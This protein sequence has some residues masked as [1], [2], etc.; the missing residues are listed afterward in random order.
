MNLGHIAIKKQAMIKFKNNSQAPNPHYIDLVSMQTDFTVFNFMPRLF[1]IT[2]NNSSC[3]FNT[4]ILIGTSTVI[5]NF[6]QKNPSNLHYHLNTN[7]DKNV[8]SKFEQIYKGESVQFD[9]S[10]IRISQLIAEELNLFG[11]NDLDSYSGVHRNFTNQ[12]K[13]NFLSTSNVGS[14][15]QFR[16]KEQKV[17]IDQSSIR[18]Y[19]Q[20]NAYYSFNIKT[21]KH[22]YRCSFYGALFS[23]VIREFISNEPNSKIFNFDY[24]DN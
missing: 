12:K 10:E 4:D 2:T 17:E 21:N 20:K 18:S 19:L 9:K 15:I 1:T 3:K 14:R 22:E 8:L 5:S 11:F 24:E 6:I 13:S 16:I 7:D 23:S